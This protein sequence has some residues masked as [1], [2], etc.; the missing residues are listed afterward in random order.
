MTIDKTKLRELV[1]IATQAIAIETPNL[2]EAIT[3]LF[4]ACF[5]SILA[6]LDELQAMT[7]ERDELRH[8]EAALEHDIKAYIEITFDMSAVAADLATE[9]E[10]LKRLAKA[11]LDA[12]SAEAK[13]NMSAENASNNF[14]DP[15]PEQLAY[16]KAMFA[17]DAAGKALRKAVEG[18]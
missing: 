6:L 8:S 10:N 11:H 9:L 4:S 15:T 13:A 7:T 2:D 18:R 16:S 14:S 3:D 17:A 12:L 1:A 5:S